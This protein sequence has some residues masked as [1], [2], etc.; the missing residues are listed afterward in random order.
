M[1]VWANLKNAPFHVKTAAATFWPTFGNFGLL[2]ILE[3]GHTGCDALIDPLTL[4][5]EISSPIQSQTM[6]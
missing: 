4:I 3:S 2:F 1:T 6:H 5:S